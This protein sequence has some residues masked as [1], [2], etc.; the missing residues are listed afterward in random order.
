MVA[1]NPAGCRPG[2]AD[3][4]HLERSHGVTSDRCPKPTH[5]RCS[6]A[7]AP[8]LQSLH[9]CNGSAAAL[10]DSSSTPTPLETFIAAARR[11]FRRASHRNYQCTFIGKNRL[12]QPRVVPP[13]SPEPLSY[14]L[15][16]SPAHFLLSLSRV[17]GPAIGLGGCGAGDQRAVEHDPPPDDPPRERLLEPP[18][19]APG[20]PHPFTECPEGACPREQPGYLFSGEFHETVVDLRVAGCGVGLDLVW[21]RRYRSRLSLPDGQTPI[22]NNWDHSYNIYLHIPEP[23]A[24]DSPIVIHD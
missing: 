10:A 7:P 15:S 11:G 8:R 3:R 17:L 4:A 6:I 23:D 9:S 22:G 2:R 18:G 5:R 13:C 20:E 24:A 12:P 16:R 19:H 14:T 21:A 1:Q